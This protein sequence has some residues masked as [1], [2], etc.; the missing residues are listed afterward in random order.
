MLPGSFNMDCS[1]GILGQIFSENGF[2]NS[3]ESNSDMKQDK[4][5]KGFTHLQEN[6]FPDVHTLIQSCSDQLCKV[7][8]FT[9]ENGQDGLCN[10]STPQA[11]ASLR[12]S[13][14]H[15]YANS[16]KGSEEPPGFT[17][18]NI[19]YLNGDK[20]D[21]YIRPNSK[22]EFL[23]QL[24]IKRNGFYFCTE[25]QYSSK[26]YKPFYSH[27]NRSHIPKIQPKF[28][29]AKFLLCCTECPF[30]TV[31]T[32]G[33]KIHCALK[34]G[35]YKAKSVKKLVAL[36]DPLAITKFLAFISTTKCDIKRK[37]ALEQYNHYFSANMPEEI[38]N[39]PPKEDTFVTFRN[40]QI[41]CMLC[42]DKKTNPNMLEE[43]YLSN[44]QTVGPVRSRMDHRFHCEKCDFST[45]SYN[46][47]HDHFAD[48]HDFLASF[49]TN[50]MFEAESTAIDDDDKESIDYSFRQD[51]P[52]LRN[53][54]LSTSFPMVEDDVDNMSLLSGGEELDRGASNFISKSPGKDIIQKEVESAD[55]ENESVSDNSPDIRCEK[56][57]FRSKTIPKLL[58][59]YK[60]NHSR[61]FPKFVTDRVQQ[62][63]LD[64][65]IEINMPKSAI[66][67]QW[68][69]G[70][71][72]N[73]C[74]R[75]I[76]HP[77]YKCRVCDFKGGNSYSIHQH[78]GQ[79]H[80]KVGCSVGNV[81][82]L[83]DTSIVTSSNTFCLSKGRNLFKCSI[84][85]D[86]TCVFMQNMKIHHIENHSDHPLVASNT[87][88]EE[89]I[90][91]STL[92]R[93]FQCLAT[94]NNMA[95]LLLHVQTQHTELVTNF[96]MVDSDINSMYV[97][98]QCNM[99]VDSL[100]DLSSHLEIHNNIH[101]KR[102]SQHYITC[103]SCSKCRRVF[104]GN[105][106]LKHHFSRVHVEITDYKFTLNDIPQYMLDH[107][108]QDKLPQDL[109]VA[110]P[111]QSVV[112][113]EED[114]MSDGYDSTSDPDFKVSNSNKRFKG[115]Q[116]VQKT[117]YY[118]CW[119]P[120]FSINASLL[121]VH[122]KRVHK[123]YFTKSK[124][125]AM[126]H[127][128]T[129]TDLT[130]DDTETENESMDSSEINSAAESDVLPI[131]VVQTCSH[132]TWQTKS[133][134]VFKK[135]VEQ[136][137]DEKHP[138]KCPHCSKHFICGTVMTMHLR[139]K[140]KFL[141]PGQKQFKP[142]DN[143]RT[144][145]THRNIRT[146]SPE[147]FKNHVDHHHSLSAP[148]HCTMCNSIYVCYNIFSLHIRKKHS[149]AVTTDLSE[150]KKEIKYGK[151][152]DTILP[153][154]TYSKLAIQAP[155]VNDKIQLKQ[156]KKY[157]RKSA[158]STKHYTHSKS[159]KT[160]VGQWKCL[161]CKRFFEDYQQVRKHT[162]SVHPT[163][164][165]IRCRWC[166]FLCKTTVQLNNHNR[167]HRKFIADRMR[168]LRTI[169]KEQ[170]MNNK[171]SINKKR[172]A[173]QTTLLEPRAKIRKVDSTV[174]EKKRIEKT[175]DSP[176]SVIIP[177]P[178]SPS[179][180][181]R[182]SSRES[183][184]P[185]IVQKQKARKSIQGITSS[186]TETE[187]NAVEVQSKRVT[188]GECYNV[189]PQGKLICNYCKY[190]TTDTTRVMIHLKANHLQTTSLNCEF[191]FFESQTFE[192]ILDHLQLHHKMARNYHA[193]IGISA[194][195]PPS[196]KHTPKISSARL[197]PAPSLPIARKFYKKTRSIYD[198]M[199]SNGRWTSSK[200][201]PG[202][203][204]SGTSEKLPPTAVGS[205]RTLTKGIKCSYCDTRTY[206]TYDMEIHLKRHEVSM[207]DPCKFDEHRFMLA[208][209]DDIIDKF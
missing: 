78:F 57:P 142:Y 104:R 98:K 60:N 21:T 27:C 194:R 198:K 120:H 22:K 2:D 148:Y 102:F 197:S 23:Q 172:S 159:V 116:T 191:C 88:P 90:K 146:R 127:Y 171:I 108:C 129:D 50:D 73:E 180:S 38:S 132:L 135:H 3:M 26:Y 31:S 125:E 1:G 55:E 193:A 74:T 153:T 49:Q 83:E 40:I 149:I 6:I 156:D 39:N 144:S 136:K 168:E 44:H 178:K 111:S 174:H 20:E 12:M 89:L 36:D 18:K 203:L 99:T 30:V 34:H 150:Y 176:S 117:G 4:F 10:Q 130:D 208:E 28:E 126:K 70:W 54:C 140:H 192:T 71:M 75:L 157:S 204:Q 137:H 189:S 169:W 87:Y 7:E 147:L 185:S 47:L 62:D 77:I 154:K 121:H 66:S 170:R 16:P 201:S 184:P 112:E 183:T 15:S 59:H 106:Y 42:P 155:P 81:Q 164:Q 97:C 24:L 86:F 80:P 122:L 5:V 84:C 195:F 58:K 206:S 188:L 145:C 33:F 67:Q 11:T 63:L 166:D 46:H 91:A 167:I 61:L 25:C 173:L 43:H 123:K 134:E 200:P 100:E 119:C 177:Q 72:N 187:T 165:L 109:E 138:H 160:E 13:N 8:S 45:L 110:S 51:K 52:S 82:V 94:F 158:T 199:L 115:M 69:N 139:K 101:A 17:E 151:N 95:D 41:P 124:L 68:V 128:A 105:R 190:E 53:Q 161:F 107:G 65:H 181:S 182:T 76:F 85:A 133:P 9:V 205:K 207:V 162:V 131:R 96:Q 37:K 113:E 48:N 92:L 179:V 202:F 35:K 143:V 19:E 152:I 14:G 209:L 196:N 141:K 175:K 32:N 118:C 103:Y 93:C 114:L 186:T 64:N 56:C 29:D 79:I 163:L